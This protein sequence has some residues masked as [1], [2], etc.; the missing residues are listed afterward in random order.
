M[1]EKPDITADRLEELRAR[2]A[3]GEQLTSEELDAVIA[4]NPLR[5]EGISRM[6]R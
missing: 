6:L 4:S 1:T 2:C 3:R 5:L